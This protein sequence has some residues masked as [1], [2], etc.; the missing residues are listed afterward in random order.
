MQLANVMVKLGGDNNN[1][2]PKA[3]VTPAEILVLRHIHGADCVIDIRPAGH[4]RKRRHEQE[5]ERLS[6][7]YDKAAGAFTAT[8]GEE[9][10]SVMGTLF[11]GALRKLPMTLA[12]IGEGSEP[13][14]E[15]EIV[16]DLPDEPE[17]ADEDEIVIDPNA[18]DDAEGG[19]ATEGENGGEAAV[20]NGG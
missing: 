6:Q 2:V 17:G 11:P 16:P 20:S 8:A 3:G 10:K 1:I 12:D 7:R 5:Y 15:P 4:D 19:G 9:R 18:D 13:V 14:P